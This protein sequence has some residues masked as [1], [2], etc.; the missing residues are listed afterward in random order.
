LGVRIVTDS[1]CDLTKQDA[2]RYGIE[3]VPVYVT[4]GEERLRDGIDIDRVQFAH[5]IVGGEKPKTEP[6]SVD[7]FKSVFARIVD[8][9][10]EVVAITLSSQIS[11]SFEHART[12]AASFAGKVHVVDSRAASGLESLLVIYASERAKAGESA[13]SIA[14]KL[15]RNSVKTAAY[16]AVPDLTALGQS[17]RLPKAVVALGSMLNVSLVLKMNEQG[18]IAPAGQS[19][20]YD[21]TLELMVESLVRTVEHS[22][23]VW[24]A[25]SHAGD[26]QTAQ[27]ISQMIATKLGHPPVKELISETTLTITAN[28]GN[29]GVGIFAIVP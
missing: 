17:G 27:S 19:R 23:G 24:V 21:K 9:R 8:A 26:A 15:E 14:A 5:R 18:A 6:A 1:G 22:P 2:V 16:F 12:A 20:S 28:L 7:D 10:D 11:K 25:I 13:S 4:F 3:I 29:A